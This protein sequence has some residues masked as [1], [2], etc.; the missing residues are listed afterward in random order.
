MYIWVPIVY[1]STS[2]R[3]APRET[4]EEM[5]LSNTIYNKQFY[6]TL[7]HVQYAHQLPQ[8][9]CEEFTDPTSMQSCLAYDSNIVKLLITLFLCILKVDHSLDIFR[10]LT[11]LSWNY[12]QRLKINLMLNWHSSLYTFNGQNTAFWTCCFSFN[13]CSHWS[14]FSISLSMQLFRCLVKYCQILSQQ[15]RFFR[16]I[17][18]F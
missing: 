18:F 9:F 13:I 10:L 1:F 16:N 12:S 5:C 2:S 14:I 8:M 3:F 11:C 6:S 7:N 15:I 17:P 4:S